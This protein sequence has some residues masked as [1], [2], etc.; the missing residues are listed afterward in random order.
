MI[1]QWGDK[2]PFWKGGKTKYICEYCK[3]E[4]FAYPTSKGTPRKYCS[5][6]CKY[7]GVK[8]EKCYQ[9]VP[10]TTLI[11]KYCG[12]SFFMRE[13]ELKK[14]YG[15]YCSQICKGKAQIGEKR[16]QEWIEMI[17]RVNTGRKLTQEHKEKLSKINKNRVITEET[18]QKYREANKGVNNPFCDKEYFLKH[19]KLKSYEPYCELFSR[20]F[21]DRCRAWYNYQ[22]VWCGTMWVPGMKQFHV[23]HVTENKNTCCDKTT[24]LFV[25][26]CHHCH[27]KTTKRKKYWEPIF[28][29]IINNYYQGKCYFTKEEYKLW[30]GK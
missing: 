4:F 27:A 11:C 23:H 22:C 12:K 13:K 14:G 3:K 16:S 8:G 17:K 1:D 26:L 28:T 18:R 19:G 30:C 5:R 7:N 20:G 10:K 25:V 6:Q 2:N 15:K 29:D 24:P 21:R 9:W